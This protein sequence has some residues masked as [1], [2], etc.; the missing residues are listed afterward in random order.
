MEVGASRIE[1]RV[2]NGMFG[3]GEGE[4]QTERERTSNTSADGDTMLKVGNQ[5]S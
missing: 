4:G 1:V 2:K 3:L 5:G